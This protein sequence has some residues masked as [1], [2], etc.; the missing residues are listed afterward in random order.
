MEL[1]ENDEM[2][3]G[4]CPI[5]GCGGALSYPKGEMTKLEGG[6]YYSAVCTK[7]GAELCEWH[8]VVFDGYDVE[9]TYGNA[10]ATDAE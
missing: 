9:C 8:K 5:K 1:V 6:G 10:D 4:Q 7:C 2:I 3:E